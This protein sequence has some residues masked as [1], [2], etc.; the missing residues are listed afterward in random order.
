VWVAAVWPNRRPVQR[1][2][3]W[4]G[5]FPIGMPGPDELA[6]LVSEV[7]EARSPGGNFDVIVEIPPDD[8]PRRWE[9][10]GATWR[11]TFF[12]PEPTQALVRQV[13]DAGPT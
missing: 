8:D 10:A 5:L 11:L 1:A 2:M 4:D 12:G 7:R 9:R 3:R 6:E 13:I